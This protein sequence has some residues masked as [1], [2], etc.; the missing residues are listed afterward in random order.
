MQWGMTAEQLG[1]RAGLLV[2]A[3]FPLAAIV[4]FFTLR[5]LRDKKPIW[6]QQMLTG[7]EG[8]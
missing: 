8:Q 1:M 6:Q 7:E 5:R 2:G 4:V 3:I